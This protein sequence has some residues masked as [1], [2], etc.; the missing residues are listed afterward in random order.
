MSADLETNIDTRLAWKVGSKVYVY[1]D[2]N[3]AFV[4]GRINAINMDGSKE[5]L[6]VQY[7]IDG[8]AHPQIK[9]VERYGE[10]IKPY[11]NDIAT[12]IEANKKDLFEEEKQTNED[13]RV[14][15]LYFVSQ[16]Y[17]KWMTM[18]EKKM[19]TDMRDIIQN[20]LHPRY[21]LS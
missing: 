3:K 19:D 14:D 5:R 16:V 13:T 1:C 7:D 20:N 4:L 8:G 12:F 10:H 2:A 18:R 11:Q 9:V 21:N 6:T 15:R 17:T